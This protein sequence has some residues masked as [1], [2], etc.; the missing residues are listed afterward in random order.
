MR[1]AVAA[2]ALLCGA[3]GARTAI[4]V[5]PPD[6]GAP[7]DAGPRDAGSRDAG[8]DA[9]E[10]VPF[11]CPP[12]PGI[13]FN[14]GPLGNRA[15]DAGTRALSL[16]TQGSRVWLA[17][18]TVAERVEVWRVDRDPAER[19]FEARGRRPALGAGDGGFALAFVDG[20]AIGLAI[21]RDDAVTTSRLRVLR[22]P[23]DTVARPIHDGR[24][25]LLG[26]T[27]G[28]EAYFGPV[29]GDAVDGWIAFGPGGP[30]VRSAVDPATGAS[31][32]VLRTGDGRLRLYGFER[33]GAPIGPREG[34]PLE[35]HAWVD[36]PAFAFS[37]DGFDQPFVLGGFTIDEDGTRIRA[38]RF[39]RDGTGG[40]GYSGPVTGEV[41]RVDLSGAPPADHESGYGLFGAGTT[42][43]AP[44]SAWFHGSAGFVGGTDPVL[45][46]AAFPAFGLSIAG[47]PCGYVMAWN[48]GE[49]GNTV[50][51]WVAVPRIPD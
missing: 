35:D 37:D 8:T 2:L 4:A 5:D 16:A 19:L 7:R 6:A 15:L 11:A 34:M 38:R 20:D 47:H 1:R 26:Y 48:D 46:E 39:R 9:G 36:V 14:F 25:W 42:A 32:V 41:F 30:A 45:A 33:G 28:F 13:G 23:P 3:C 29:R 50:E 12:P 21:G 49:G 51:L 18:E 27:N 17:V 31:W 43:G 44:W 24:D 22:G 40:S 10:D